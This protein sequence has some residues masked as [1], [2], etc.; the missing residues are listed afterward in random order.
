[1]DGITFLLSRR[2]SI[3]ADDMGLGK[4]RQSILALQHAAP[5]GPWLV[6]CP[7]SVKLNWK[8]E[9]RM[10]LGDGV[11]V[12]LIDR[13]NPAPDAGYHSWMVINYDILKKHLPD[14]KHHAFTGIVFD[15]A[16][17]LKNYTSQRSKAA[18]ALISR[19]NSDP[20]VHCLTGTPL[21]NRPRDLFPLLQIVNHSLGKSF[22]SFAKRYCDA[23]KGEY[24]WI[25]DGASN[26]EELTVQLHGTMLRRRKDEVLNL[27]GKLRSWFDVEIADSTGRREAKQFLEA[28][29]HAHEQKHE[30]ASVE[31]SVALMGRLAPARKKIAIAKVKN[32]IEFVDG[33]LD[34]G[35]K[36]II[37]SCFTHPTEMLN[38]HFGDTARTLTGKT[39]GNQ[40]QGIVD[41]FQEDDSVRVLIANII[42]GGVGVNLTAARHVV[43]NDLDW[44]P[45][46]HW[47]AE[48]RAYRI[49][50]TGTVNVYYFSAP[51]TLDEFVSE[52]LRTK[53][54]IVSAVVEGD[55]V[56]VEGAQTSDV[57]DE[58]RRLV[59][60][61]EATSVDDLLSGA[62][63]L[64]RDRQPDQP[65]T[66]DQ[67][68]TKK[69][70]AIT[71]EAIAALAS[72]LNQKEA[73]RYQ[74]ANS[75]GDGFY[76]LEVDG[77]DVTCS[78][79]GFEFRGQCKHART[80]KTAIADGDGIPDQYTTVEN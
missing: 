70:S 7:A 74:M 80:L 54:D 43:F 56:A 48:D 5:E 11:D 64:Y 31:S 17:Y 29:V 18:Q 19:T 51:G 34:Q 33:I 39:P 37:Y 77:G 14:L 20:V 4:T 73:T 76:I 32:T 3:L 49:G 60:S 61:V 62:A 41:A 15:E 35:E 8:R 21:T 58:L 71:Q 1:M 45:A 57:L 79:R 12:A 30:K 24:G 50:Q 10:A 63:K 23:V 38:E 65:E 69:P 6:V 26:I 53:S 72:A 36:A 67:A 59:A 28:V 55:S 40:R 22:L 46:N 2:R 25:T 68:S 27:P 44:V 66:A 9:I 42:A 16:H 75:K 78:C 47:Q 52:V 13:A